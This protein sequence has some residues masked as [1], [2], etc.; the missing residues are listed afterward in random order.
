MHNKISALK[1]PVRSFLFTKYSWFVSIIVIY[2]FLELATGLLP[3]YVFPGT[4]A[5]ELAASLGLSFL[6]NALFTMAGMGVT[7]AAF[8]AVVQN[9]RPTVKDSL[10]YPFTHD[11]DKFLIIALIFTVIKTIF[12][13]PVIFASIYYIDKEVDLLFY[14][15]IAAG[16]SL[17]ALFLTTLATLKLTWSYYYLMDDPSLSAGEAL[18]K[19]LAFSKGRTLEILYLKL[20]FVGL[21]LLS[22][23]SMFVGYLYTIPYAQVT[24]L[25]YYLQHR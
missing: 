19:S 15:G 13:A 23:L 7:K 2:G 21:F 18:K 14:Y 16:G 6:L 4:S 17:V 5:Y 3:T 1:G 24:Y 9:Q 10:F 25:R 8:D 11:P 12:T 22:A 20:S